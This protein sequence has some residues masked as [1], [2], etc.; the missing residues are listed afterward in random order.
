MLLAF[1]GQA[2]IF[3]HQSLHQVV[4]LR[5]LFLVI[6]VPWLATL[7]ATGALGAYMCF[8]E[9]GT[10]RQRLLV[11]ALPALVMAAFLVL[12]LSMSLQIEPNIPTRLRLSAMAG[13]MIWETILPAMALLIGAT[14]VVANEQLDIHIHHRA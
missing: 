10:P 12:S 6:S 13:M 8:H 7:A 9:G 11:A 3:Q 1:A 14:P 4:E 2:I 5:G